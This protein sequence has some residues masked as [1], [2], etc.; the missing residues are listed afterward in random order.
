MPIEVFSDGVDLEESATVHRYTL[1]GEEI[2]GCTSILARAGLSD[3][4]KVRPEVLASASAMGT[5]MHAYTHFWDEDDLDLDDLIAYPA[6]ANRMRGWIQFREDWE[7][8]PFLIERAM[9]IKVNGM[10]FGV[11]PDRFGFGNFGTPN[12][13]DDGRPNPV[14]STVEIKCTA[15]IEPHHQIQTAAQA[16]ALKGDT[17]TPG[18]IL[19]QLHDQADRTGKFYTIVKCEDRQDESVFLWALG[20]DTW[21][22]NKRIIP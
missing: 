18:R 8:K 11:K 2:P 3:L 9:A 6:Y 15:D 13:D 4:S 12:P 21:K 14:M 20:L 22:R 19:C 10:T 17:P 5:A 7:F 16:L 1:H